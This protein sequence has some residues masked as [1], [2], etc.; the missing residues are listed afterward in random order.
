MPTSDDMIVQELRNA[1]RAAGACNEDDFIRLVDRSGLSVA[2]DGSVSGAGALVERIKRDKPYLFA[3]GASAAK[4]GEPD[5]K[6]KA[7][8]DMSDAEYRIAVASL[9]PPKLRGFDKA[10]LDKITGGRKATELTEDEFR[11]ASAVLRRGGYV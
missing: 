11:A 7:V 6:R 2:D 10:A 9:D 4:P 3:A 8:Q 1:A 5:G